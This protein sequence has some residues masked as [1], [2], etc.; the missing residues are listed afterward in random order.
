[1][2][3]L[4]RVFTVL[5]AIVLVLYIATIIILPPLVD[6]EFNKSILL[7]PYRASEESQA[8][9]DSLPFIADLHCDALLWGRDLEVRNDYG[10]VDIQE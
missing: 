2:N 9:Y 8:L 1:M 10:H 4:I 6:K 3:R 5:L 7:P